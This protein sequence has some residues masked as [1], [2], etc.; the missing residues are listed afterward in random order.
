[1]LFS[2]W[3]FS[4]VFLIVATGFYQKMF[5]KNNGYKNIT[6]VTPLQKIGSWILTLTPIA[7]T[8][9]GLMSLIILVLYISKEEFMIKVIDD[10]KDNFE[11]I[12]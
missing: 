9:I 7:N 6:K 3:Y 1:M 5:L 8:V 4:M 10:M 2:N 12:K 11:K